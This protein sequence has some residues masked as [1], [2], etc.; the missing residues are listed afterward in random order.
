MCPFPLS[1]QMTGKESREARGGQKPSLL[2]GHS[3]WKETLVPPPLPLLAGSE[4]QS[5]GQSQPPSPPLE[6]ACL[7][8]PSRT[9]GILVA[10]YHYTLPG[11][12]FWLTVPHQRNTPN[13]LCG[14][15]PQPFDL[16]SSYFSVCILYSWAGTHLHSSEFKRYAKKEGAT[17]HTCVRFPWQRL[18][19][20]PTHADFWCM[21]PESAYAQLSSKACFTSCLLIQKVK[22]NFLSSFSAADPDNPTQ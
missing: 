12:C 2:P 14:R 15:F 13:K 16:F 19:E 1:L 4:H 6:Q 10:A 11:L 22:Y 7:A 8:F 9:A 5:Q 20:A 3:G 17:W 21:L 18:P